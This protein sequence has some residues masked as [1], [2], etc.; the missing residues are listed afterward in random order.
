MR[1]RSLHEG[2]VSPADARALQTELASRVSLVPMASQPQT[3][4][5]L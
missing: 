1:I 4:A 5:A 3:V 2:P